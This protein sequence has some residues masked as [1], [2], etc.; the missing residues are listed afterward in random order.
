MTSTRAFVGIDIATADF[1]V[2]CRPDGTSWTASNDPKG[3]AATVDRLC[4]VA[5]SLIVLEATGGYE[6]AL[7]AALAAATLPLVVAKPSDSVNSLA[8]K[9][10]YCLG[11]EGRGISPPGGVI[12]PSLA[13]TPIQSAFA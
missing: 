7:V 4:A 9:G 6:T 12:T 5:P 10:A 2:A 13:S 11:A 3:I 8:E 1:V